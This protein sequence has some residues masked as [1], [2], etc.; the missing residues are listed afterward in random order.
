[1]LI[2]EEPLFWI[3][4]AK[5]LFAKLVTQRDATEAELGFRVEWDDWPD[6]KHTSSSLVG[7]ANCWARHGRRNSWSGS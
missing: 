3:N 2:C 5:D 6:R 4:H 1:M 7:P